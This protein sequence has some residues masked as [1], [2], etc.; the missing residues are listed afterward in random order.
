MNFNILDQNKQIRHEKLAE[1]PSSLKYLTMAVAACF[2]SFPSI[3]TAQ[4]TNTESSGENISRLI[5]VDSGRNIT[6]NSGD[7]GFYS[8]SL[9]DTVGVWVNGGNFTDTAPTV[10]IKSPTL[11]QVGGSSRYRGGNANYSAQDNLGGTIRVQQLNTIEGGLTPDVTVAL[12]GSLTGD[13]V[14]SAD[15]F[16][17]VMGAGKSVNIL[18]DGANSTH[19][20]AL[21][22]N[23]GVSIQRSPSFSGG[24]L[25]FVLQN[26]GSFSSSG[27]SYFIFDD[28]KDRFAVQNNQSS[29]GIKV[30]Q[31]LYLYNSA[32]PL[33]DLS[34]ESKN[35]LIKNT[36]VSVGGTF[37]FR[38]GEEWL[39]GI[40]TTFLQVINDPGVNSKITAQT[41]ELYSMTSGNSTTLLLGHGAK[42]NAPKIYIYTHTP[43]SNS[44][45]MLG[46]ITSKDPNYGVT[47]ELVEMFGKGSNKILFNNAHRGNSAE[48]ASFPIYGV[49]TVEIQS[50]RTVFSKSSGY[51]GRTLIDNGSTL[52]LKSTASAGYS[53]I[54]DNGELIYSGA[55]GE[56]PNEIFGSGSVVFTDNARIA[57]TKDAEWTGPTTVDNALVAMGSV[58]KPI[59]ISSSSVSLSRQAVLYGFGSVDGS[60]N[61]A[62]SFI[63]GDSDHT[64]QTNFEI[65]G[66]LK[67]SGEIDLGNGKSAGNHLTVDGNYT[68]T[69][70]L[71]VFNTELNGDES[72]TD[73]LVVKGS[74]EGNTR[75]RVTNVGGT[76]KQ[77]LN[78]IEIIN[79]SGDSKGTFEQEGR[80]VA[81]AYDYRLK[82]GTAANANN[83]YL[84]SRLLHSENSGS[85]DNRPKN[86][87]ID[88]LLV[89]P[90]AGAYVGNN[91]AVRTL[92]SDRLYDRV[93]DLWYAK[94]KAEDDRSASVWIR[95]RG[96]YNSWKES[97]AQTK[98]RTQMYST[99]LGADINSWTSS[100]TDRY[101]VGWLAGYGHAKTKSHSINSGYHAIGLV[102]GLTV[103]LTG[104]WY[105]DR[106]NHEGIYVDSWLTYSWF[107]NKIKG[108]TLKT[109]KYHSKGL[110]AS[111]ETGY[112]VKLS[113]SKTAAGTD[114]GWY[115]QPQA[116]I[117]WSGVKT[118]TL[119]EANG[120]KVM[121][122]GRNNIQTR[123]GA[124]T[125]VNINS[126][127]Y[128]NG[129]AGTQLFLE[130]N[131]IHNTKS[132]GIEMNGTAL[133]QKGVRNIG[134]VKLGLNGKL[135]QN[136]QL[137]TNA[138]AQ[139]GSNH[140]RDLTCMMGVKYSF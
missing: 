117:I 106:L 24:T 110:T 6:V 63:V 128:F 35:A 7:P 8:P 118:D 119:H 29:D 50:G 86:P 44:T 134:E 75:I 120:T 20:T 97:T 62:G 68:G 82:R 56:I 1:L 49:G 87:S 11:F 69:G 30:N 43:G 77:T 88:K 38:G 52:I 61:N 101:I 72:P 130:G 98:N 95:Q 102:D 48:E 89:R 27:D 113:D 127:A 139:A 103:G 25:S 3:A 23:G 16:Y 10:G 122:K 67:N 32:A 5:K 65:H 42:L 59:H 70:G 28:P 90:E 91:A 66:N 57:M 84:T 76:G 96:D 21:K 136:L 37:S 51:K 58:D 12:F 125:F 2:F 114:V 138:T 46:D 107:D 17:P 40:K 123:L 92:F 78:G 45:L 132:P 85:V 47:T 79:V 83:W 41:F 111:V 26:S 94:T 39:S 126:Q 19:E 73:M 80:I 14:F 55:Q 112:T 31:G 15:S 74:T 116:Q 13:S 104:T 121:P 93:G 100:G 129:T 53:S 18:I 36:N 22:V 99:Q 133:E 60:L 131:W 81:G 124:R 108:E 64:S 115:L 33:T 135:M 34:G 137:W 140:Y 54:T 109:E 105:Q 4:T 9:G 71:M